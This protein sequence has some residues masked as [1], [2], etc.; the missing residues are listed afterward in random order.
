VSLGQEL[1]TASTRVLFLDE[2]TSGLD[3]QTAQDIVAQVRQLADDG[4]IVFLVTHDVSPTVMSMVD[5]LL[6]LAPG[7][8]LAWFGPPEEA[9]AWF[10][11]SSADEIFGVLGRE[12]PQEWAAKYREGPAHRKYVRTRAHVLGLDAVAPAARAAGRAARAPRV[13]RARDPDS[14]RYATVKLRD[15][16]GMAV[17]LGQAPLLA[18]ASCVVFPQP[19]VGLMFVLVLS[20][21]WFGASGSVRELIA[22]RS[23]WRRERRIGVGVAPYVASKVLVLGTVV[24]LQC[25]AAD[26]RRSGAWF[27]L[28]AEQ[29][30]N[31]GR[32]LSGRGRADGA[33]RHGARARVAPRPVPHERGGGREP[34]AGADPADH[35]RGADRAGEGHGRA[36]GG[37]CRR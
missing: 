27:G 31:A 7:G 30:F 25:A 15:R 16:V 35:L 33:R 28:G 3:P 37:A 21:L 10:G 36:A 1:L 13:A 14:P 19:D 8:R 22:E 12:T 18:A 32:E 20:A 6:V 17:L 34:A 26:R 5:H 9:N 4:R 2:P 11:V 29:G 23:I 24:T